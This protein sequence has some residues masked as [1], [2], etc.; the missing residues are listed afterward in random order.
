MLDLVVLVVLHVQ[1][2]LRV[3]LVILVLLHSLIL[4]ILVL[5][6]QKEEYGMILMVEAMVDLVEVVDIQRLLILDQVEKVLQVKDMM[7][8][9]E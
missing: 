6:E 7:V 2:L 1:I 3:N 4:L 9:M 8:V 5:V